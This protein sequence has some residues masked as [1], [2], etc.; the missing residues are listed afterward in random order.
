MTLDY[1]RIFFYVAR[2]KS[3][4]KAAQMLGS[5]Q[6][7]ITRCMNLLEHELGCNLCVRTHKG[8]SLTPEGQLLYEHVKAAMYQ[9]K[10]G[11][12]AIKKSQSLDSGTITIG[13]SDTALR[14]YLSSRLEAFLSLYPNVRIKLTNDF[15]SQAVTA[16]EKGLV[17]FCVV[18]TP[19]TIDRTFTQTTLYT[20]DEILIG[21]SKY[22]SL[23][24]TPLDVH[25]ISSYPYI[26]LN[27]GSGSYALYSEYFYNHHIHFE[28]EM[29]VYSTDQIMPLIRSN[30]GLAFYP[31]ELARDG[32]DKKEIFHIQLNEP[33]VH[34]QVCLIQDTKRIQSAAVK[35]FIDILVP[36]HT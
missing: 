18:T 1:Y 34:R 10:N 32:L 31:E 25:D 29:L 35:R 26:T 14:L 19:F 3:F 4:S 22:E 15:S 6:P 9:L 20:F 28:P 5:N 23:S 30:L 8:I 36:A 17:D 11:Q 21:G 2:Y 16:L 7:N 33:P 27:E 24:H 13:V 12:D